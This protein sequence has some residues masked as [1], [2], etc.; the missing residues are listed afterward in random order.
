MRTY[1]FA[2][3]LILASVLIGISML[4]GCAQWQ[5]FKKGVERTVG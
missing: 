1:S 5:Q 3:V 4:S 2:I